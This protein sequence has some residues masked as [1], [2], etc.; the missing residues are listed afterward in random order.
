VPHAELADGLADGD[1]GTAQRPSDGLAQVAS[2]DLEEQSAEVGEE[3][4]TV[5]EE[6]PQELAVI[7]L[8]F[9]CTC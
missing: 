1:H 7:H 4:P 9:R 8:L 5:M 3:F 2:K 6:H